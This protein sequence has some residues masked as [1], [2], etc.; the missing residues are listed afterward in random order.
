MEIF[1][2]TANMGSADGLYNFG[3][4]Y[5]RGMAGLDRDFVRAKEYFLRAAAQKPFVGFQDVIM[6]NLGVAEAEN[7]IAITYRDGI[8][9]DEN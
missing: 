6:P 3:V 1:E 7:L 8:G 5:F 2:K 9:V 4:M